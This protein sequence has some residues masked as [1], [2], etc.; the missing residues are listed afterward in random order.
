[1]FSPLSIL[2]GGKQLQFTHHAKGCCLFYISS[3][4]YSL[5]KR[6]KCKI[7]IKIINKDKT[8]LDKDTKN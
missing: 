2:K 4:F 8:K 1:M 7:E 6:L 3:F 5:L